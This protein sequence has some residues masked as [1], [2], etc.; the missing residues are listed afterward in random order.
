MDS[1]NNGE[2][3]Y[4]TQREPITSESSEH[5]SEKQHQFITTLAAAPTASLCDEGHEIQVIFITLNIYSKY[6]YFLYIYI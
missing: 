6:I 3:C 1:F 2:N 5:Q 4:L